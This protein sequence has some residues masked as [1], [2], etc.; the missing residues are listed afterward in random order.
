[1]TAHQEVIP[2]DGRARNPQNRSN[3][4]GPLAAD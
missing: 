4:E 2:A 1:M 3:T